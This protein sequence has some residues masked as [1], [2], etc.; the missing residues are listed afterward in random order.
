MRRDLLQ[1]LIDDGLTTASKTNAWCC[2]A[3]LCVAAGS[4]YAIDFEGMSSL[5]AETLQTAHETVEQ[6][7][8][9]LSSPGERSA[10]RGDLA[11]LYHAQFLLDAAELEYTKAIDEAPL[12]RWHYLR[13]IVR[14][15]RGGVLEA[16]EDFREVVHKEPNNHLALYRLGVAFAVTGDH[17]QA[18]AVLLRAELQVPESP[19]VLAAL[20]D[21]AI[22]AKNWRLAKDYLEQTWSLEESG[23]VA[24]KLGLVSGR[25]GDPTALRE[26]IA[27]R[28]AVAPTIRDPLLLEVADRSISPRFFVKAAKWA[29]ER[30]DVDDALQ[31]YRFASNLAPKDA[32]I[33]L[34]FAGMLETQGRITEA[35]G[36]V[37][38]VVQENPDEAAAWRRLA[39][40]LHP[41]DISAA[42]DAAKRARAV[43]DD[44][45]SRALLAAL[46][47]K[48]RSYGLASSLYQ[49]L[50]TTDAKNPYYFYW[51]A[52]ARLAGRDC[53]GAL[54]SLAE[55]IRLRSSW[56]E[57]HVVQ[58]RAYSLC[59]DPSERVGARGKAVALMQQRS[60]P[61]MRLTLAI[62]DMSLGYVDEARVLIEAELPHPDA[63]MLGDALQR[64]MLPPAPFAA[65]ST[66][67]EPEEI[68]R[69]LAQDAKQ[70][71]G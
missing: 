54:G 24:Y 56:G 26:W 68:R 45:P 51:L 46:A 3:L 25:L 4:L 47:M 44:D 11:M 49:E 22:A 62:A 9:T 63:S 40:L 1:Q 27:R 8:E 42:L 65:D 19:A 23:Q 50:T 12:A 61:D 35:I 33:G 43:V 18:R 36:E 28:S 53:V 66:W 60:D 5:I 59:G 32:V 55:A 64:N 7:V 57:A 29:W 48:A 67:W 20:G 30:G 71:G 14:M 52:M 70:R 2:R 39:S 15:D 58:I 37:R 17:L 6:D 38:R 41:T 31:A 13:G 16:I 21:A 34:G 69:S 10:A